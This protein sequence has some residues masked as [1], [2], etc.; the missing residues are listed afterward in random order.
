MGNGVHQSPTDSL[1]SQKRL[2]YYYQAQQN[3]TPQQKENY[4]TR[5]VQNNGSRDSDDESFMSNGNSMQR[6]H[7]IGFLWQ[8]NHM[9]ANKK[10]KS[11]TINGSDE[12]FQLRMLRDFRNFCANNDDRLLKFW[13]DCW[14]KKEE[15]SLMSQH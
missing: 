2:K 13:D 5:H 15:L 7:A 1:K 8:W 12:I 3:G 11:L 4:I 9:I 6:K 14:Q 10:W